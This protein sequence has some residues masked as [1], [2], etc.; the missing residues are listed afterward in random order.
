MTFLRLAKVYFLI[1]VI[2]VTLT[3]LAITASRLLGGDYQKFY[4]LFDSGIDMILS[5][6]VSV[7][8]FERKKEK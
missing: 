2:L 4:P 8:W 6:M 7:M 3:I 1:S 5:G